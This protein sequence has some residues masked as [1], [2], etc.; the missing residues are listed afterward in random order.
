MDPTH[1]RLAEI[2]LR[3]AARFGFAL[4]GGYAVQEHGIIQRL[5]EDV[6]LFTTF[7]RMSVH[8]ADQP[9]RPFKVELAAN[10][11]SWWLI[12][13][14]PGEVLVPGCVGG[15]DRSCGRSFPPRAGRRM[16][17]SC[18]CSLSLGRSRIR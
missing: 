18:L 11:R 6:D 15:H 4:A 12:R 16:G 8:D 5:S 9:D 14:A 13:D 10:W 2:G 1:R 3:A 7:A 17:G